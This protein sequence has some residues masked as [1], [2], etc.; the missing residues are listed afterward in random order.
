MLEV[1][2]KRDIKE[3]GYK[4]MRLY[5]LNIFVDSELVEGNEVKFPVKGYVSKVKTFGYVITHS[6][7]YVTYMVKFNT[8]DWVKYA[9]ST[10][11]LFKIGDFAF[12]TMPTDE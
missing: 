11:K 5:H 4:V 9:R 3:A 1:I 7:Y 8:K 12:I 2:E 10:V 6:P